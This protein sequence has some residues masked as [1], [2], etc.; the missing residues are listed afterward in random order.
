M[1]R[2]KPPYQAPSL[3]SALV[4]VLCIVHAV[5]LAAGAAAKDG[6]HLIFDKTVSARE[7]YLQ[8]LQLL[9]FTAR[10]EG[11]MI[12]IRIGFGNTLTRPLNGRLVLDSGDFHLAG[13]DFLKGKGAIS[14][15][16]NL[17][18]PI[19]QG[20]GLQP[21]RATSGSLLFPLPENDGKLFLQVTGFPDLALSLDAPSFTPPD[22]SAAGITSPLKLKVL[23]QKGFLSVLP[24]RVHSVKIDAQT[25][26]VQTSFT[27]EARNSLKIRTPLTGS[28][29]RLRDGESTLHRPGNVSE[30]FVS[31]I[32]PHGEEW[33]SD[34]ENLGT[35]SFATPHPHAL[36][37]LQIAFPGYPEI[38]MQ[39]DANGKGYHA[40]LIDTTG[41]EIP[42]EALPPRLASEVAYLQIRDLVAEMSAAFAAR[43]SNRYLAAF[44]TDGSLRQRQSRFFLDSLRAP[45][46]DIQFELPPNQTF[47]I[48]PEGTIADLYLRFR[49]TIDG[50]AKD[51]SFVA[52]VKASF[53]RKPN[54]QGWFITHFAMV[55]RIPFWELGY[56]SKRETEHFIILFPTATETAEHLREATLEVERAYQDLRSQGFELKE[57]HLAFFI[58]SSED[59]QAFT[60]RDPERFS[61]VASSTCEIIGDELTT[62]NRA[63]YINDYRYLVQQRA[64]G[65][66]DRQ[67]TI[68]HELVHLALSDHTR[69][70]TPSWLVEGAA[71]HY[72]RQTS[73]ATRKV[74]Q[75]SEIARRLTHSD[76]SNGYVLGA[77]VKDPETLALMYSLAGETFTFLIQKFGTKRV[78]NFYRAF[79][80]PLP[81]ELAE[82][83][84]TS[85]YSPNPIPTQL[86]ELTQ[87]MTRRLLR[88]HFAMSLKEL[89]R[90]LQTKLQISRP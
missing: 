17:E 40:A 31:S 4:V 29:M 32:S 6:R 63:I 90:A 70:F 68:T 27:N 18:L 26:S 57:K 16:K 23:S 13:S 15:D 52:V 7:A 48:T 44:R 85:G 89:T 78:L 80:H 37:N 71:V 77:G 9:A 39:L 19:P 50:I 49:Y 46:E 87:R 11:D 84:G 81:G 64:W 41:G 42:E 45:V 24:W 86:V 62:T 3:A 43:D 5:S 21:H 79:A 73:A 2:K 14:I 20:S 74:L 54:S 66:M 33:K 10:I 1:S 25:I 35:I 88:E 55:S 36:R 12:E 56:N 30:N 61:G 51:N 28:F 53:A 38:R 59:F 34:V 72:A 82:L 22:L 67:K 58:P 69:P 75:N 76:M 83:V 65:V 8:G 47:D 60:T